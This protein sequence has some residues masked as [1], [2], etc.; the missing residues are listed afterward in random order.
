MPLLRI[1]TNLS[2]T[3]ERKSALLSSATHLIADLLNKP[4][5]VVM[6]VL[7]PDRAMALAGSDE[8]AALFTVKSIGLPAERTGELS[9]ALCGLLSERL[10]IPAERVY[11]EFAD[12]PRHL[13]GWNGRTF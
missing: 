8:P 12:A 7:E 13:W 4:P 1:E 11:I 2:P 5:K 6:V 9:E 3:A 10:E